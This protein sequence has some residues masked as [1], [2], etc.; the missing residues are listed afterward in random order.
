MEKSVQEPKRKGRGEKKGNSPEQREFRQ[1]S[2]ESIT[3]YTEINVELKPENMCSI[4][5]AEISPVMWRGGF[6][7]YVNLK[8]EV[9]VQ[10]N[11]RTKEEKVSDEGLKKD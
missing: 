2:L 11:M 8:T 4:P 3:V 6:T 1:K 7:T 9:H 5:Y 10:Y